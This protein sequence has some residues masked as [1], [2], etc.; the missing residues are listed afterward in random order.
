MLAPP[1]SPDQKE[2]ELRLEA[3]RVCCVRW[4]EVPKEK[5]DGLPVVGHDGCWN[6]TIVNVLGG[7]WRSD[8]APGEFAS[9]PVVCLGTAMSRM[10]S[11]TGVVVT[12]G[13]RRHR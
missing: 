2:G 9:L 12:S 5:C 6:D 11:A 13:A 10:R 1:K 8:G 3:K 7:D 4:P